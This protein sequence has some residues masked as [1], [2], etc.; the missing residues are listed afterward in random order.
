MTRRSHDPLAQKCTGDDEMKRTIVLML[1]LSLQTVAL[2]QTA[3]QAP[4]IFLIKAGRLVDVRAGRVLDNQGILV[5]GQRIKAVGPLAT[6][7][8]DA[9]ATATVIDLSRSTVLPGLADC[10][11]HILLQGDITSADYDEQL[12]KESIP[13]RAIRA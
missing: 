5:E 11:T 9:P 4:K 8:K 3:V 12:L 10:H 7:Q 2:A 6:I 1:V 13:Y